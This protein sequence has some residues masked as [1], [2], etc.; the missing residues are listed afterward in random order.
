MIYVLC[1]RTSTLIFPIELGKFSV[2]VFD[3]KETGS[4][5]S[6][7]RCDMKKIVIV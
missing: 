7:S 6:R 5:L 1:R 2:A 3:K 4:S